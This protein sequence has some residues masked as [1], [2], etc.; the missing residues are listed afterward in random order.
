MY[1]IYIYTRSSQ[2]VLDAAR[3]LDSQHRESLRG[4]DGQVV[5]HAARVHLLADMYT[6]SN[7]TFI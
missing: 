6:F 4:L 3:A 7:Y 1:I 5:R 2:G